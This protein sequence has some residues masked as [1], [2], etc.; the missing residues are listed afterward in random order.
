MKI[1][2]FVIFETF[3]D[4]SRHAVT[5]TRGANVT[6][7]A[8]YYA[9]I[10]KFCIITFRFETSSTINAG[11]QI[12]KYMNV[13]RWIENGFVACVKMI[14]TDKMFNV[15]FDTYNSETGGNCLLAA[16]NISTTGSF[17]GSIAYI[18]Y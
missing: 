1:I 7:H 11:N 5:L 16:E 2:F 18:T 15:Y 3:D 13:P 14:G 17:R 9:F 12:F 6:D 10:G 4:S 8:V